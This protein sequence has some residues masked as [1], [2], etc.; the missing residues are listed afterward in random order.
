MS[1]AMQ[2]FSFDDLKKKIAEDTQSRFGAL[3]PPEV[4]E[5]LVEKAVREFFETDTSTYDVVSAYH[6]SEKIKSVLSPFKLMV[7]Q[8]VQSI[9]RPALEKWFEEHKQELQ[10]Q[11]T[12]HMKEPKFGTTLTGA[13]GPIATHMAQ[14]QAMNAMAAAV[15]PYQMEV[16]RQLTGQGIH[17]PPPSGV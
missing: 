9:V 7:W 5:G 16:W 3:I 6:S 1:N 8:K 13:V 4:F 17:L 15:Q 11:M 12:E 10:D 14:L 2:N